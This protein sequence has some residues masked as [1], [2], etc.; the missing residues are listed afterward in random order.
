MR[1]PKSGPL[2]GILQP[3]LSRVRVWDSWWNPELVGV[4]PQP[5][6]RLISF[7]VPRYGHDA[8]TWSKEGANPCPE[9][10]KRVGRSSPESVF[11]V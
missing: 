11:A 4:H 2:A 1:M 6:N 3:T 7:P 10:Q 5:L 8:A 9:N